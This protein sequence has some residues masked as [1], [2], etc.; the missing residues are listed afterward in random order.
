M[1]SLKNCCSFAWSGNHRRIS[2]VGSGVH[3]AQ[4]PAPWFQTMASQTQSLRYWSTREVLRG[5]PH[6]PDSGGLWGEASTAPARTVFMGS[7]WTLL[8]LPR[9]SWCLISSSALA[10]G[11][12]TKEQTRMGRGGKG[13]RESF[14]AGRRATSLPSRRFSPSPQFPHL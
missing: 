8:K 3:P 7:V 14:W 9:Q 10:R 1:V 6:G 13:K 11:P 5:H 4:G 12:W 2:Q